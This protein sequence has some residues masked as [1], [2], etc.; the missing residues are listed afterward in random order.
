MA[1]LSLGNYHYCRR[2]FA[3]STERYTRARAICRAADWTDG[4]AAAESALATVFST[5]GDLERAVAR[6]EACLALV[7]EPPPATLNNFAGTLMSLGRLAE[8]TDRCLAALAGY[9]ASGVRLGEA[10]TRTNLAMLLCLRG[11]YA[12]ARQHA[13]ESLQVGVE[14]D[15]LDTQAL[16]HLALALV[17]RKTGSLASSAK[18]A[19][20]AFDLSATL[21][22]IGLECLAHNALAP[23]YRE[24]G[25]TRAALTHDEAAIRLARQIPSRYTVVDSTTSLA[26]TYAVLGEPDRARQLA[27]EALAEAETAGFRMLRDDALM[28]LAGLA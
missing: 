26:A 10:L 3:G 12:E 5:A 23:T 14:W 19:E 22:D 21:R 2:E 9:R 16:A 25:R 20:R 17:D 28:V 7:D 15:R 4:E 27:G 18:H 11:E 24:L 6:F 1:E 8:A 13:T